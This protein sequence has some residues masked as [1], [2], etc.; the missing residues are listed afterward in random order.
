MK[1]FLVLVFVSVCFLLFFIF[2]YFLF[3]QCYCKPSALYLNE[4]DHVKVISSDQ[5]IKMSVYNHLD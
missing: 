5:V 4:D 1:P 2:V 3:V